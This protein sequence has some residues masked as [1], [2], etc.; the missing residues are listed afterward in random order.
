MTAAAAAS[1]PDPTALDL[2]VAQAYLHAR[3]VA[4]AWART[5][6]NP[7]AQAAALEYLT[8]PSAGDQALT[9]FWAAEPHLPD[10]LA[11]LAVAK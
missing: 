6:L 5:P 11:Q 8:G 1:A 2:R 9:A 4:E 7:Q 3:A 10:R